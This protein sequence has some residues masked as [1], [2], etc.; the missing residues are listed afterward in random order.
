[1][2]GPAEFDWIMVGERRI[3]VVGYTAGG[4]L[5]VVSRTSRTTMHS[6]VSHGSVR[7]AVHRRQEQLGIPANN[8]AAREHRRRTV[9]C[10]ACGRVSLV[11]TGDGFSCS[12]RRHSSSASP[13]FAI[14]RIVLATTS[15]R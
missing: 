10:R 6:T 1:M 8:T 15:K 9:P 12:R 5:T 14:V 3:F 11:H 4:A 7:P 2:D 13:F